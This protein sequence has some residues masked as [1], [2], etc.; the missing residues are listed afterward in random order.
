MKGTLI[1]M[2][3]FGSVYLGLNSITG[4][5]MAVKQ[6]ELPTGQ[7]ANEVRKKSMVYIHKMIKI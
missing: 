6:V 1:G 2:G 7:S 4:E 3:S 5:L